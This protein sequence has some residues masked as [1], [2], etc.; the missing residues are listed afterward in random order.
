M[1]IQNI[2]NYS[3]EKKVDERIKWDE[4]SVI[5]LDV[6]INNESGYIALENPT[7]NELWLFSSSVYLCY[8]GEYLYVRSDYDILTTE[9]N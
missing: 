4:K 3:Y 7:Q 1:K 2:Y 8:D 5:Q 9:N 6:V